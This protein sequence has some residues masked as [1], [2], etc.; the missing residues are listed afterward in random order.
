[1]VSVGG[2]LGRLR[3]GVGALQEQ[4]FCNNVAL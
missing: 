3:E 4:F 2:G 1:M